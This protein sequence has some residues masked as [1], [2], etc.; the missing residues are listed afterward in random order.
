M[1]KQ[2]VLNFRA[3]SHAFW[4]EWI[5]DRWGWGVGVG[6][7]ELG[8][9][10]VWGAS[11]EDITVWTIAKIVSNMGENIRDRS[12]TQTVPASVLAWINGP[13]LFIPFRLIHHWWKL[14][15]CKWLNIH[16]TTFLVET[17]FLSVSF[18]GLLDMWMTFLKC[19]PTATHQTSSML[20]DVNVIGRCLKVLFVLLLFS[21]FL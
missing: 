7:S 10:R 20:I 17:S 13:P 14:H 9:L 4:L 2:A 8:L 11:I 21:G 16:K 19:S 12:C 18:L 6:G 15:L 3:N 1:L 5:V